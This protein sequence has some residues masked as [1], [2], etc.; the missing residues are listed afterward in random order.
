MTK[1]ELFVVLVGA[2]HNFRKSLFPFFHV[3]VAALVLVTQIQWLILVL[4]ACVIGDISIR[5]ALEIVIQPFSLCCFLR[6]EIR[7]LFIMKF[8]WEILLRRQQRINI[9]RSLIVLGVVWWRKDIFI[10]IWFITNWRV[11]SE[12]KN[13]KKISQVVKSKEKYLPSKKSKNS[14]TL[15]I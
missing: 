11:K 8:F 3:L 7:L 2:S 12:E 4:W 9:K 10:I 15:S 6:T 14:K 1:S 13:E 5:F